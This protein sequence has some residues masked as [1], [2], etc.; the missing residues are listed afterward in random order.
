MKKP[1]LLLSPLLALAL[2]SCGALGDRA[3]SNGVPGSTTAMTV[4]DGVHLEFRLRE[5]HTNGSEAACRD[6]FPDTGGVGTVRSAGPDEP[7]VVC[8]DVDGFL[9]TLD[10]GPS[11][12]TEVDVEYVDYDYGTAALPVVYVV[13][14]DAGVEAWEQAVGDTSFSVQVLVD[15]RVVGVA[16]PFLSP[17]GVTEIGGLA[18]L[19][20]AEA[21]ATTLTSGFDASE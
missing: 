19:E 8:A 13:F 10:L 16:E 5:D 1:T 7:A 9:T 6:L 12:V 3:E 17:N 20:D 2:T 21:L 11:V 18:T 15:G 14:D 4:K